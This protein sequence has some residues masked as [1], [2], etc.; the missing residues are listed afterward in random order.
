[1]ERAARGTY[2]RSHLGRG[3]SEEAARLWRAAAGFSMHGGGAVVQG[4][5]RAVVGRAHGG[6]VL[7]GGLFIGEE[8]RWRRGATWWP[9]G[10]LGG[11][12]LMAWGQLR[13]L[14]GVA[15]RRER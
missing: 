5:E 4:R 12:P 8:R 6:G 10:E 15:E 7:R 11:A 9:A 13:L 3:G 14:A 2:P 1:M